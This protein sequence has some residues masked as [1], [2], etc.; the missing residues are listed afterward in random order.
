LVALPKKKD[1]LHVSGK[2]LYLGRKKK[3]TDR[4]TDR[5]TERRKKILDVKFELKSSELRSILLT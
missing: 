4:Q 5:Q 1:L 2:L 3:P